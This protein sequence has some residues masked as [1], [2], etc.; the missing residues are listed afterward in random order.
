MRLAGSGALAAVKRR[1]VDP[2]H[3]VKIFPVLGEEYML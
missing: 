3:T 1:P 2:V